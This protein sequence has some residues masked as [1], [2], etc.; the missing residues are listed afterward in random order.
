MDN[1]TYFLGAGASAKAI[2]VVANFNIALK[3]FRDKLFDQYFQYEATEKHQNYS[4]ERREEILRSSDWKAMEDVHPDLKYFAYHT[5]ALLNDLQHHATVDTLARRYFLSE[6][7]FF[8]KLV[9]LKALLNIF[10]LQIQI[11]SDEKDKRY[12]SFIATML[13]RDAGKLSM[14]PNVKFVSWN[15]D[16]QLELSLKNYRGKRIK[17][18]QRDFQ[19][20]P[21]VFLHKPLEVDLDNFAV[22]K[23]NG[24]AGIYDRQRDR[25][26]HELADIDDFYAGHIF[27]KEM[28][29]LFKE[30]S[31]NRKTTCLNFFRF[32]WENYNINRYIENDLS[33]ETQNIAAEIFSDTQILVIIGYSFPVF[34]RKVDL[35]LFE[36]LPNR[37]IVYIQDTNAK[38]RKNFDDIFPFLQE[39]EIEVIY[40]DDTNQFHIPYTYFQY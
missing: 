29:A 6:G 11:N 28:I 8:N 17:D 22:V 23:L 7:V 30:L 1:I 2:P 20:T 16:L 10:F 27:P 21:S 18:I 13:E 15:Y 12:D 39:R 38:A 33:Q 19:I 34:N 36:S 31:E 9:N 3:E 37:T 35:K 40:I 14:P 4:S 5:E 24:T 32:S 25:N 26:T